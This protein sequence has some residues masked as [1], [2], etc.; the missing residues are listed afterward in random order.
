MTIADDLTLEKS[1]LPGVFIM[2]HNRWLCLEDIEE[3]W[4][5]TLRKKRVWIGLKRWRKV[6][7]GSRATY[8]GPFDEE[9]ADDSLESLGM[10]LL[11]MFFS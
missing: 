1:L 10:V 9:M 5:I 2:R 11:D 3:A 8:N 4:F 6:T 7:R